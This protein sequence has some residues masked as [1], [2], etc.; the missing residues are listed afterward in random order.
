[1]KS[2]TAVKKEVV[3]T[4]LRFR[5]RRTSRKIMFERGTRELI[6]LSM[7]WMLPPFFCV[8]VHGSL[9]KGQLRFRRIGASDVVIHH[10][11][12]ETLTLTQKLWVN[13]VL[14][15]RMII[16]SLDWWLLKAS[17]K[18]L[19]PRQLNF[20]TSVQKQQRR[21]EGKLMSQETKHSGLGSS[22]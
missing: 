20:Y 2:T 5:E 10:V 4:C 22:A 18:W 17:W 1:M 21:W 14:S 6:Y 11:V 13:L 12:H 9:K 15:S 8:S 16:S 3:V 19:G 7:T